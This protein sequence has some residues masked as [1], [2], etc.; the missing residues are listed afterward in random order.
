MKKQKE[1]E[2]PKKF[3][4]C[5]AVNNKCNIC[6]RYFPEDDDICDSGHEIGQK[7]EKN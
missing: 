6:G 2:K 3:V 1:I 7:Y 5:I 4:T